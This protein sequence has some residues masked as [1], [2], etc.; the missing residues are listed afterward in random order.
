MTPGTVAAVADPVADRVAPAAGRGRTE[1]DPSALD[2]HRMAAQFGTPFYVYDLDVLAER[3]SRLRRCLP[4]E[5]DVAYAVKANP[6]LGVIAALGAHGIGADVASRGELAA[7]LRAGIPPDRI[8]MTGPGKRDDELETAV[9]AG[10][11]AITVESLG[12]FARLEA[13]AAALAAEGATRLRV[14]ILLRAASTGTV[15]TERVPVI[16]GDAPRFG[17]DR[18]DLFEAAA[19]AAS[20]AHLDLVGVH[21][22]G[23]SNVLDAEAL[24]SHA[25]GTLALAA[26]LGRAAGRRLRIVDLGGG[27]GIPYRDDELELDL[28]RLGGGLARLLDRRASDPWLRDVRLLLEPGR[29]LAGP[30]GAYVTRVLDVKRIAGRTVVTVDGGVHHFLRPALVGQG[31][32]VVVTPEGPAEPELMTLA[33]PL[34]T[35]LDVLAAGVALPPPEPGAL[36]AVR[37]AG[38]YGFTESMPLFLSHP[39]PAEIAVRG[40]ETFLVRA[41]IDPGTWLDTQFVPPPATGAASPAGPPA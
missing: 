39:T 2:L 14:P 23:A 3:V 24:V 11:R 35:G 38:A 13:V 1:L 32:R 18:A 40:G 20:S 21:A 8:V 6:A 10:L 19:L 29:F 27:L 28:A 25:E 4:A 16:R 31:H 26:E 5:V 15:P 12:E 36:V 34:C 17:M 22:F 37:D 7:A 9:R 30:M 33:G 41:R